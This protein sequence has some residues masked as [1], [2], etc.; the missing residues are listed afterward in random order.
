MMQA[1][2]PCASYQREDLL[3]FPVTTWVPDRQR[4]HD[5]CTH[6][7]STSFAITSPASVPPLST[8]LGA[9]ALR[10]RDVDSTSHQLQWDVDAANY[11]IQAYF[12]WIEAVS[13]SILSSAFADDPAAT[14]ATMPTA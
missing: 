12:I 7:F 9:S 8:S 11:F 3:S 10:L 1:L 5:E 6:F 14:L 13:A 2:S 4:R